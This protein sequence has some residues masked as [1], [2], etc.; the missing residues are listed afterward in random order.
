MVDMVFQS[1]LFFNHIEIHPKM[2][3]KLCGKGTFIGEYL[4][5][6]LSRSVDRGQDN[7]VATFKTSE[8][9]IF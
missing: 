1:L 2:F 6:M 8:E 7:T 4:L 9:R 5:M 3:W